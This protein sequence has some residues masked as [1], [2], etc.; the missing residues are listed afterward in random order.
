MS[1]LMSQGFH[2]YHFAIRN[3][4]IGRNQIHL[5]QSTWLIRLML[6]IGHLR[7]ARSASVS[8]LW[9]EYSSLGMVQRSW[10]FAPLCGPA[11]CPKKRSL[12]RIQTHVCHLK[13]YHHWY[14]SLG[15]KYRIQLELHLLYFYLALHRELSLTRSDFSWGAVRGQHR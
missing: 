10:V 9:F 8:Y 14:R 1:C 3:H 4:R 2:F 11:S 12:Y 6:P 15:W 7:W 13:L 5:C